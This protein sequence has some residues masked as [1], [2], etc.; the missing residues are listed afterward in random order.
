MPKHPTKTVPKVL[1][2]GKIICH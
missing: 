1:L 2:S